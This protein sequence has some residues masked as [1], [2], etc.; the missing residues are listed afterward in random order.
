MGL[1]LPYIRLYSI[2]SGYSYIS[3]RLCGIVRQMSHHSQGLSI[4]IIEIFQSLDDR[5]KTFFGRR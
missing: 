3:Q 2:I 5:L 1:Y 4:E